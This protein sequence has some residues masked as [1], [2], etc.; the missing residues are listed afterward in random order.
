MLYVIGLGLESEKDI[1]IRGLEAV[2]NSKH[3]FLESYTSILG[4]DK[5][6][7]EDLYGKPIGLADRE[8]VETSSDSILD[9]ALHATVSFLVV[10]DPFGATTHTDLLLRARELNVKVEIIHNASI[11]NAVGA[12]GL[13]LYNFGQTISLVFFTDTWKPDSFYDKLKENALL[14]LHSLILLD[15][16]VK[17]QSIENMAR[18]RKVYEPPRYMSASTAAEQLLEIEAIRQEDICTTDSLVVAVS[19]IGAKNQAIRVGSLQELV[20]TDLGPPLHSL[21]LVGKRIHELEIE[22]MRQFAINHE[23]YKKLTLQYSHRAL[24]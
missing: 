22:Y 8:M 3:V 18:G 15:I 9:L 20:H 19:K 12:C 13:Q 17:E 23:T 11:M 2:Q 4:V 14:G 6:R 1:T 21:V 24:S 5:A 7:L 16:K 10:G